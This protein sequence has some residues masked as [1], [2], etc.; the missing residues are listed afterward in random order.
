MNIVN[1]LTLRYIKLNKKRTLITIIGVIISAA[2]ITGVATLGISFMDLEKRQIISDE[3]EWHVIYKDINNTQLQDI[4]NDKETKQIMLSRDLG[5]AILNKGQNKSRPY[6]F[7]R[8]YNKE[9][10]EKFPIELVKGRFPKTENEV[11]ISDAII[12]NAKVNYKI[13]DVITVDI[14]K[15]YSKDSKGKNEVLMQYSDLKK[16]KNTNTVE[17]FLIKENTKTYKIVGVIKQPKFESTWA[18]GYT[19]LS[20]INENNITSKEK[21]NASITLKNINRGLFSHAK[22]IAHKNKI[23]IVEF[24][25]NLLRFYGVVKDDTLY[26]M[27]LTL[28]AIMMIIIMVGSISLIYNAFAISVSERSRH[29]GM[30]SSVGATKKQKRNSVFFEGTVIGIISIPIGIICGLLG[31]DLTFLCINHVIKGALGVTE[32]F[33]VV[34]SPLIIVIAIVVSAITIL[35]S[36]YVPAR[37]ASK[38]SAIDA[39]RQTADIKLTGKEV[40]VSKLTEKIFGIEGTIGLKNLKRNKGRYK[41]VVFSLVISMILFL[42]VS[43]F[44]S[45]LKKSLVLSQE[46]INFD[47]NI[48]LRDSSS[49]EKN[50]IIKKIKS[51]GNITEFDEMNTLDA[52]VWINK[53]F[54]ADYLKGENQS[55][56]KN[57]AYPYQVSVNALSDEALKAYAK[58]VGADL[59]LLNNTTKLSAIVIDTVK[60]KD[61]ESKKYIETKAVKVNKG[62]KL[63]LMYHNWETENDIPLNPV[64]IVSVTDKLPMGIL[65]EGKNP[66]FNIV[67]SKKVLDKIISKDKNTIKDL[68]T[69]LFIKSNDPRTLQN[70]I[71]TIKDS[72]GEIISSVYNVF[73]NRQ[74]DN[75]TIVLISVFTYGFIALITAI[76]IAN[77]LNTISTSIALRKR[78]FAMLKSVG[79]TPKSFNK[80][81]NYES[82]FYGIKALLY[83]IPISIFIMYLIHETLMEKFSFKFTLPWINILLAVVAVFIIVGVAMLYSSSKVKK[84]N[85]IYALKNE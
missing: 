31:I 76:C 42:S 34:V 19:V 83:G 56:M 49:E 72:S 21:V 51:L 85:I 63:D 50:D 32:S 74:R 45:Y 69:S 70:G 59:N 60:Y 38:I 43:S 62:D 6:M 68:N 46:G 29:L 81:I 28:S 84:E 30:L 14:G 13:G 44:T 52:R 9:G 66:S 22:N 80:M 47:I 17:E 33:R 20:Y 26:S 79:M 24:N 16:D 5:C 3:G 23:E 54:I 11:V 55:E 1:K 36:T 37:K 61:M 10:F 73:M 57:G 7:I 35:I 82:I 64:E 25:D 8:E 4:K 71:E 75:Q 2:M 27:I 65:S 77:I 78:E 39:I 12:N 18:P 40:K 15:R 58:K 48:L 67:V 41:T 53:E